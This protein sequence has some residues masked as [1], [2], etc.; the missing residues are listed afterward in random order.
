MRNER[1]D[2]KVPLDE[3]ADK[4]YPKRQQGRFSPALFMTSAPGKFI[5]R[6]LSPC[7]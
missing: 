2:G 1:R 5:E 3:R 7:S 4:E 6:R